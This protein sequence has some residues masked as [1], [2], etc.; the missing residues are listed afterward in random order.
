MSLAIEAAIIEAES[1][2]RQAM[3][4]SDVASLDRL[5]SDDLIFTNHL[6]QLLSKQADLSAHGSG[7]LTFTKLEPSEQVLV[8][9]DPIAIVSV[10]VNTEGIYAH[11]PF[12]ARIRYT[13]IWARSSSQS[14]QVLAGHSSVVQGG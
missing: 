8:I 3:L 6:G 9:H 11:E 12:S 7:Q 5:I 1:S 13:R 4:I 14:W 2:L 10:N